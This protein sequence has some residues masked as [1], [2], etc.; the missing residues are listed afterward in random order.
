MTAAAP[1][2]PRRRR[3]AGPHPRRTLR[4]DRPRR[5]RPARPLVTAVVAAG[6]IG[7]LAACSTPPAR[8]GSG[9]PAV[10]S[11]GTAPAGGIAWLVTR[12]ALADL[13]SDTS[14]RS[15]LDRSRIYEVLQPGQQRLPGVTADPV[16]TFSSAA[17]LQDAVRRRQ[18]PAGTYGV[19]YDP[20]AWSFT[21]AAEQH[22]PVAAAAAAAA[23]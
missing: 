2:P 21:P 23:T 4:A 3:S 12:A 19:L 1:P 8:P 13:V 9:N 18:L 22:N 16:V 15:R 20:E 5:R 11:S 10:S 6:V 17:A 7:L 14:V